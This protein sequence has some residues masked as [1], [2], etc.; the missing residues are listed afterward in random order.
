MLTAVFC[1]GTLM[2][3]AILTRVIGR[4]GEDLEFQDALVKVGS[5]RREQA[6]HRGIP[7]TTSR[8][9]TTPV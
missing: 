5:Q 3:P 9:R 6:Y 7:A 8:T 1:Y 4:K 2:V